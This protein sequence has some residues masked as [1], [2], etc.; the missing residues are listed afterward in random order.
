MTAFSEPLA[1]SVRKRRQAEFP[2]QTLRKWTTGWRH[3]TSKPPTSTLLYCLSA[4]QDL[5]RE[6]WRCY[7]PSLS[8]S[9]P[10]AALIEGGAALPVPLLSLHAAALP[11]SV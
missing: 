11:A 2:R 3:L 4:Q 7:P 5:V 8:A 10:A 6:L 9:T 1:H